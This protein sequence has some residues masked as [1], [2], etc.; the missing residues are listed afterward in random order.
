[1][2]TTALYATQ[3]MIPIRDQCPHCHAVVSSCTESVPPKEHGHK[4]LKPLQCDV[5]YLNRLQDS[6]I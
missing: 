5:V 2:T 1:M 3:N 4:C 6:S